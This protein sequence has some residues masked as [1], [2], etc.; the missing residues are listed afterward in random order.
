MSGYGPGVFTVVITHQAITTV[1]EPQVSGGATAS[2]TAAL[3]GLDGLV[4]LGAAD[5]G[6]QLDA[7]LED[8]NPAA[9]SGCTARSKFCVR[10][11]MSRSKRG[12]APAFE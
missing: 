8:T 6:G 2:E 9:I 1:K 10:M 7:A 3:F 12:G 5:A 4:V 11:R